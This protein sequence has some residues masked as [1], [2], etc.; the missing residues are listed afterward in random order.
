M[1]ELKASAPDRE[2]GHHDVDGDLRQSARAGSSKNPDFF[3]KLG[4]SFN[5][6]FSDSE[7]A[8]A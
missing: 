5:E 8:H 1:W 2:K 4:F 7:H 3:T 6:Q